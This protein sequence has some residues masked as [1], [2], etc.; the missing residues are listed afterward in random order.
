[1]RD[2]EIQEEFDR[3]LNMHASELKDWLE[4]MKAGP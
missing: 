1:M 4:R 3:L 2:Q